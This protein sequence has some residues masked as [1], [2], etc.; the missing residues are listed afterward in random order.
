MEIPEVDSKEVFWLVEGV[1]DEAI[2]PIYLV[3]VDGQLFRR[4]GYELRELP[5][6]F[7]KPGPN[8]LFETRREAEAWRFERKRAALAK[9]VTSLKES[10]ELLERVL[11]GKE[12]ELENLLDEEKKSRLREKG[13]EDLSIPPPQQTSTTGGCCA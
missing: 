6:S 3:R 11:Q 5:S 13:K 7:L 10:R 2:S 8:H 1:D 12:L 4:F 9:T